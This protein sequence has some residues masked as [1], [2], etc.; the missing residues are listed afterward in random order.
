MLFWS[1]CPQ[2]NVIVR[3]SEENL[4]NLEAE[5]NMTKAQVFSGE[6]VKQ[7]LDLIMSKGFVETW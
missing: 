6:L 2:Y 4:L 1:V 3:T 5:F 7:T